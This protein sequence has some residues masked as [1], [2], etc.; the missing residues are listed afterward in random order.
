MQTNQ[1]FPLTTSH[2]PF[3]NVVRVGSQQG[4]SVVS[5]PAPVLQRPD[6][7]SPTS[8]GVVAG[9]PLVA[10]QTNGISGAMLSS[11][12][13]SAIMIPNNNTPPT[14]GL[15]GLKTGKTSRNANMTRVKQLH[16]HDQHAT[17]GS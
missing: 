1:Q 8:N 11:T 2:Y 17:V 13:K 4:L 12:G 6:V 15:N 7:I 5:A 16:M 10:T 14:D 3:P 9:G